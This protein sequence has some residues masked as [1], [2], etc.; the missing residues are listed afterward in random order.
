MNN[1]GYV[2]LLCDGDKFKIGMTRRHD[3]TKRIAELQTGNSDT[4]WLNNYYE[5]THPFLVEKMMHTRYAN[6]NVKNEWF[7]LTPSQVVN[8]KNE[9]H[10]CEKI[11]QALNDNPFI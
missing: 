1:F 5:T 4:I 8:F 10:E 3:I 2:Y 11:I 9:C 7:N 6:S